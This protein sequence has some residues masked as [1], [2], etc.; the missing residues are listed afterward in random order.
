M[1]GRKRRPNV[2]DARREKRYVVKVTPDEDAKLQ[3][4]AAVRE[5][6]VARL[7]FESAMDAN[8]V[9]SVE[10]KQAIAMLFTLQ[11]Q[12]AGAVTNVNQI[13]KFANAE[14]RFPE[15]AAQVLA[16]YRRVAR[17]IEKAL[18]TVNRT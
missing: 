6:T 3:A 13:A 9:P 5:V 1:F 14:G 8:V 4:R 17:E 16:D 12:M 15:E 10:R 7:L 11:R 2:A 18:A